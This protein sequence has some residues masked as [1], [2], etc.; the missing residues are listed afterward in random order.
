MSDEQ[1]G[2]FKVQLCAC[3]CGL[4]TNQIKVTDNRLGYKKGEYRKFLL[5]HAQRA[6]RKDGGIPYT[7]DAEG[8]W[9][10]NGE[11]NTRGRPKMRLPGTRSKK[12]IAYRYYYEQAKGPIP[13]GYHIDHRCFNVKC[14]NPTHLEAVT[15][16]ENYQRRDTRWKKSEEE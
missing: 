14:V 10:W 9:V 13:E 1:G 11:L 15:P 6:S 4:P 5:N 12:V 3:G 16:G 8:C 7:V 2:L